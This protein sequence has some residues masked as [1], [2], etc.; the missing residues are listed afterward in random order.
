M[1]NKTK[2]EK[3]R[4]KE[5]VRIVL[6]QNANYYFECSRQQIT[7]QPVRQ[8]EDCDGLRK[9]QNYERFCTQRKFIMDIKRRIIIFLV[10]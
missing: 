5:A 7:R 1:E 4:N 10:I 3:I 8:C 2:T 9:C 6:S